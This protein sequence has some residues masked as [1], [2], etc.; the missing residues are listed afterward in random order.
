[1]SI[2][3]N[4]NYAYIYILS[5]ESSGVDMEGFPIGNLVLPGD[6]LPAPEYP[7]WM[8]LSVEDELVRVV[9]FDLPR[10]FLLHC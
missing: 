8:C 3:T 1:M 9:G 5:F 2:I 4:K 7:H 10:G 6:S